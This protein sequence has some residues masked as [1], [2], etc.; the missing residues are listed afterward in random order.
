MVTE[1]PLISATVP[2]AVCRSCASAAADGHQ[3][4]ET[5]ASVR[6][7]S[8][9]RMSCLLLLTAA[10][11]PMMLG[12]TAAQARMFTRAVRPHAGLRRS[13]TAISESRRRSSEAKERGMRKGG[14]SDEERREDRRSSRPV[15][16]TS[17]LLIAFAVT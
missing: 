2:C 5:M 1:L 15:A 4:I 17:Y 8:I 13:T 9:V 12:W 11:R 16:Q 6:A 7:G 14:G 10:R 3:M